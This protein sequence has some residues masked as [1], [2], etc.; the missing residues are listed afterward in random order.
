MTQ[1]TQPHQGPYPGV[2]VVM[3]GGGDDTRSTVLVMVE[4][5]NAK[6]NE[7]LGKE[8]I[9]YAICNQIVHVDG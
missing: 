4:L 5:A 6:V 1:R 7:F 3:E 2:G 8:T 9:N